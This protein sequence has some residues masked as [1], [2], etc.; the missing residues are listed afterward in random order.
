MYVYR[1]SPP[2]FTVYDVEYIRGVL[3]LLKYTV[4]I[5]SLILELKSSGL[6]CKLYRTPSTPV[7]YADDLA[8]CSTSMYNLDRAIDIVASHGRTLWYNVNAKKSGILVYSE[9][10]H[11]SGQNSILRTFRLDGD[12]VAERDN[13]NH[14]GIRACIHDDD[15][16]GLEECIS[17]ARRILNAISGLGIRK[18]GLTIQTCKIIFWSVVVPIATYGCELLLLTDIHVTLLEE[19]QEYA[20]KKIQ[21]F[22]I[23]TPKVC[24]F[25]TI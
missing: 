8:T 5:N 25:C 22:Y 3:S 21:R 24:T 12:I 14:V 11:E 18:C 13:Y 10:K 6:C 2:L 15:I 23:N 20:G 7:G 4:F 16:S 17:K 9:D 19:F 1:D